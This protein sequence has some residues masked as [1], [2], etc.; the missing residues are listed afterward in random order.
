MDF[1]FT[2]ET[3]T[4]DSTS[5]LTIGGNGA[6]ELPSGT[7]GQEP[8]GAVA[9]A[10]RWNTTVPQLEY[11]NGTVWLSFGGTVTSVQASG[12]T[13][14]LT[15][16]GGPITSAGTL[17]LAGTLAP[18]NGGTGATA[19]PTNGQLLIGN[20]TTFSVATLGTG[21]GISITAGAGTLQVNNTGVTSLVAGTA[22]SISSATGAVTV[23]N[24]GV[25]SLSFGTTGLTPA[26]TTTGAI[27]VA[28][29][30]VVGNGGTGAASFTANGVILGN[31]TSPLAVTAVGATGTV[32]AGNTGAAPTFQSAPAIS[33]A[34]FTAATIPNSALV[35]SSVTIGTTNIALGGTATALAGI[36]GITLSSGT[37]TGVAN[38]VAATDVVNLSYLQTVIAGLEWKQ[39]S[40]AATTA[41]LGTVT[42]NNGA[43]GVGATLTNAGTQVAFALD[44][45]SP[46]IGA[47]VLIKNQTTATQNGIY[48]VTTVG[49]GATNWVLTRAFD[50]NT[51]A[52]MD[53]AT[54]F[55]TNGTVN[56]NTAWTQTTADPTIGTNNIVFV[57]N[58]GAGTYT[59]GT[60]LTLTGNVFS[61]T[62]VGTAGTFGSATSV[63]VFTTN[64]QG[65]ITAV[66]PTAITFPVTSVSGTGAGIS[67]TPTTGA[68]VVSNTGVTSAVAGTGIGVS[69]ATGAVTF[70]N[71]GVLSWSGGTTGLTPSTATTGVVTLGGTLVATNGGTG[72]STAPTAG[73]VLVGQ[74][75]GTYVPFTITTG[76]GI[77]TT[78]GSGTLQINNTGVTSNVAGTGISVSGATGAVT[79][80]ITPVGT[81]GTYGQVT[82]NASGQVTAG[83]VITDVTHGGT[84]VATI[85]ANGVIYGNGTSAVGVVAAGSTGQVLVATTGA[86]PTWS[87]LSG[88]AVTSIAGTANQI[89]ASAATGAVTLST[90][91]TFIAP[92]SIA[93]T[94][95]ITA[96]TGLTLTYATAN[97]FVYSGAA[98]A[99][100]STA[101]ATNGQLLI[102][103]T[104]A[105]PV[106]AAITA[107]I[108]AFVTNGAGSITIA[109]P[110]YWAESSTAPSTLPSATG[111]QSIAMGN[112]AVA[113]RY[114][115]VAQAS[116]SFGTAGDAQS[117]QYTLRISTANAT[118]A[119]LALDGATAKLTL[120]VNSAWMYDINIVARRTDATGTFGAWN[121][122]GLVTQDA[123]AATTTVQSNSRTFVGGSGLVAAS[124]TVTADVTNGALQI[125]VTGNAAQTIRWVATARITEVANV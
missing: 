81:A 23:N 10:L 121:L 41:D 54:L 105:A 96:A 78:T 124:V 38:P 101:A 82:T 79:V 88:V 61:I 33:G 73:Q 17:T 51:P 58:S 104:G 69:G 76:T 80:S 50:N 74:T 15:F 71:S 94:S 25:T 92:G 3:I 84:G 115:Q 32:L 8:V 7:T 93:S 16:S 77:S 4:P 5:I 30:L 102:G 86:A 117:S 6:L 72:T 9:G 19:V 68:V 55:V 113:S 14:G 24:T 122:K 89:T 35:N 64:A 63:P 27:T 112:S 123:T 119:I 111:N 47:R 31:G 60:G 85:A 90:P 116:G 12:G 21:T 70:S 44:G 43:A 39:E 18:A 65:Q 26:T 120:P 98:S 48:T 11:Y 20:G 103:S 62:N 107:G 28:G 13:T 22:I 57:Q 110:K 46:T 37:V 56:K 83:T 2:T 99:V 114:G 109:G 40:V 36:T 97:A 125:N 87:T 75:G 100:L 34:N 95:T 29:T 108:N 45:F 106:A 42:Y 1:D 67:V 118:P 59:A 66:T 52:G 91:A 49:S 53:N